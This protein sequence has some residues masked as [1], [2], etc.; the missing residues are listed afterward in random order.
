M[1]TA[2][3]LLGSNVGNRIAFLQSAI[4]ELQKSAGHITSSSS[5]YETAAW[6]NTNQAS[7]YN[8]AVEIETN[9]YPEDLLH[10]I[11]EIEVR[12]G[13]VQRENWGPR[14]IDIDILLFGGTI[15]QSAILQ[16]PH[17]FLPER[18]FALLPLSTIAGSEVHPVL[19]QTVDEL[20]NVCPDKSEVVLLSIA[21]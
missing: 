2:F 14:E 18:R 9:L 1:A 3:L 4:D 20:L 10:A 8:Q 13:R 12:V 7:F 15:W 21:P 19:G 5:V 17:P 11:K 6:G 16:I